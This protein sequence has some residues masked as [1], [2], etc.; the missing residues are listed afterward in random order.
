MER[1]ETMQ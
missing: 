1:V